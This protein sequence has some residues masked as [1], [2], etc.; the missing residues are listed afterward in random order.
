M[1]LLKD[2]NIFTILPTTSVVSNAYIHNGL[3]TAQ[4]HLDWPD[5]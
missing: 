3:H 5:W 4:F 1:C 2:K